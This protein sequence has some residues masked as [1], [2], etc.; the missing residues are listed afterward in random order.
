MDYYPPLSLLSSGLF[1]AIFLVGCITL[2][3]AGAWKGAKKLEMS[4]IPLHRN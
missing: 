1:R 3:L 4:K 2:D